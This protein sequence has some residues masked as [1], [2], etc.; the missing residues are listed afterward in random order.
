VPK[1]RT[2]RY[3]GVSREIVEAARARMRV[4]EHA[5][6]IPSMVNTELFDA[7]EFAG[8]RAA[9][10]ASIRETVRALAGRDDACVVVF[11]GRLD[12]RKRVEDFVAAARALAPACAAAVFLVVGG[13]DAFQPGYARRL[14]EDAA[15]L[16][17]EGRLAF[18]GARADVPGILAA[19]DILVLPSVGEGMAHVIGEAGAAGLAVVAS[20]AGAAREQ[21]E[22]GRCGLLFPPGDVE[23]LRRKLRTLVADPGLRRALGARLRE[24]VRAEY[25]ARVV[26]ESWHAVLSDAARELR[27]SPWSRHGRHGLRHAEVDPAPRFPASL[28]V[29]HARG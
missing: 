24:R 25:A 9:T 21:L 3:I 12:P 22:D 23:Q 11:V 1:E 6:L 19:S 16:V 18:L 2:A 20:D 14:E 27:P 4:P 5:V 29:A 8:A 7:P 28:P 13:H 26:M 10:A 15:D 17:A